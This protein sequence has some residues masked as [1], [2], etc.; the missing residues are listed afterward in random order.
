MQLIPFTDRINK[1]IDSFERALVYSGILLY[2]GLKDPNNPIPP[3]ENPFINNIKL[4]LP[5][6]TIATSVLS[7]EVTFPID[8][9]VATELGLNFID[10]LD[11]F[12]FKTPTL[13]IDCEP[14]TADFIELKQEPNYIDNL[15]KYFAWLCNIVKSQLIKFKPNKSNVVKKQVFLDNPQFPQVKY[16]VQLN[17]DSFVFFRTNNLL[18]SLLPI[19]ENEV[20]LDESGS[21]NTSI[22][23]T[24]NFGNNNNVGNGGDEITIEIIGNSNNLGNQANIGN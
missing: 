5:D 6:A 1:G 14:S 19:L 13:E 16:T 17:Y 22:N 15:E 2:Q 24:N 20:T 12:G 10:S 21:Q 23:N 9:I 7:I 3:N 4:V 11:N 18:C 8:R